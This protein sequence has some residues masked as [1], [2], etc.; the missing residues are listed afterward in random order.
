MLGVGPGRSV[1]R[2]GN[3]WDGLSSDQKKSVKSEIDRR[4]QFADFAEVHFISALH[5]SNVGTLF[6]AIDRAYASAQKKLP[7]NRLTEILEHAVASHSP[8]L[9]HGRRIKLRY[10]HPGGS[11]PPLIVIH[12]NQTESVPDHYR[13]YLENVFRRELKLVGTPLKIEF[14][15]GTNPYAGRRNT[16]TPRQTEKRRRMI[17]HV[18]KSRK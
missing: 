2:V 15:T 6:A 4:L 3:K 13:R 12:G 7:T 17:Q 5:G 16:L 18:K 1:R 11:N 14:I 10:A 8:P 9:V